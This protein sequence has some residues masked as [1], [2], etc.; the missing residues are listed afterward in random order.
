MVPDDPRPGILRDLH[1]LDGLVVGAGDDVLGAHVD[2]RDLLGVVAGA[3]G[4]D[5]HVD[6]VDGRHGAVHLAHDK[7]GRSAGHLHA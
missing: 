6:E 2:G 4:D 3:V 1:D 7:A 5:G